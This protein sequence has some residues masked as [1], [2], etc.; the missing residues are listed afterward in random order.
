VDLARQAQAKLLA[1]E[2]DGVEALDEVCAALAGVMNR[3][4]AMLAMFPPAE[5][6]PEQQGAADVQ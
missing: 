6:T 3:C 5:T 1:T 4:D 2:G